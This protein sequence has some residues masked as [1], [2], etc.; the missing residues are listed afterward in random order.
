MKLKHS[1]SGYYHSLLLKNNTLVPP[2]SGSRLYNN[3]G[4]DFAGIPWALNNM[5]C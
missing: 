5:K 3:S 1:D 2:D 4:N